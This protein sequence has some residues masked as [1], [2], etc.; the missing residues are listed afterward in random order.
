MASLG[1]FPTKELQ[2]EL[3]KRGNPKYHDIV[4]EFLD[5]LKEQSNTNNQDS[6][7][8]AHCHNRLKKT[9]YQYN[10]PTRGE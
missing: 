8:F 7:F 9:L 2:A 6:D 1:S 4:Y 5:Y 10:L 3:E